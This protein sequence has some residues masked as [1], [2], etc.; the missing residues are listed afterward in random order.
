MRRTYE[1]SASA[2]IE[3]QL[4]QNAFLR[5]SFLFVGSLPFIKNIQTALFLRDGGR[6]KDRDRKREESA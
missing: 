4:F 3:G 1:T 2:R 5:S 6:K